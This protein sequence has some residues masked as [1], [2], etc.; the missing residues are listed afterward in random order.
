V[1]GHL[2]PLMVQSA[3]V[4]QSFEGVIVFGQIVSI[5]VPVLDHFDIN[6][7]ITGDVPVPVAY[8]GWAT[9]YCALYGLIALLLALV[10]FED[11]DLA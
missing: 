2:T 8:L 9:L 5:I 1:L 3:Q 10:L 4:A 11:R 6:A 7:A